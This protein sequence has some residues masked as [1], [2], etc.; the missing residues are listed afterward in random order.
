MDRNNIRRNTDHLGSDKW[1]EIAAQRLSCAAAA[2]Q[3]VELYREG[4]QAAVPGLVV[5][6]IGLSFSGRSE[7]YGLPGYHVFLTTR[8]PHGAFRMNAILRQAAYRRYWTHWSDHERREAVRRERRGELELGLGVPYTPVPT[9]QRAEVATEEV[10]QSLLEYLPPGAYTLRRILELLADSIFTQ[11]EITKA[12]RALKRQER[13]RF[14]NLDNDASS[15][16][17]LSK[18]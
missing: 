5:K 7:D 6:D 4:L 8:N 16:E 1:R 2:P 14:D 12:L 17:V 13:V 10:E 15:V 11:G 18:S 3:Y 9:V